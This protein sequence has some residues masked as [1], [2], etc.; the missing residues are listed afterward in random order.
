ME[1]YE[2]KLQEDEDTNLSI[3]DYTFGMENENS[4]LGDLF[5]SLIIS[6]NNNFDR[7]YDSDITG[8]HFEIK[9]MIHMKMIYK[10]T[11]KLIV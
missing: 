8:K 4:I 10:W 2:K 5:N 3:E 6:N 9:K 11:D 1:F 7:E